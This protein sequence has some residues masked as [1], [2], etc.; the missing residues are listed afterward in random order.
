MLRDYLPALLDRLRTQEP[1]LRLGLRSGYQAEMGKYL[2]DREIDVAI[3]P[4]D[5][6]VGGLGAWLPA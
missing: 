4:L 1:K 3:I 5:A 6:G 2:Q